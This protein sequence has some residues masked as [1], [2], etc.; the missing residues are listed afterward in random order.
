MPT[1]ELEQ[2]TRRLQTALDRLEQ[3]ID[4][5]DGSG[6]DL[7]SALEAAQRENAALR[8][9]TDTVAGRL[10]TTIARLKTVLKG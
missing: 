2:A 9:L 3:A 5:R 10:D 7:H 4:A 8:D 6:E 1:G